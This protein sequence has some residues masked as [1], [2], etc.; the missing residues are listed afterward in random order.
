[1]STTTA[2][3]IRAAIYCRISHDKR[4]DEAG[5]DRQ[6]SASIA[7]A[8][9]SGWEIPGEPYVDNDR[10]AFRVETVDR[11][12]Y[13]AL[14]QAVQAGE[15]DVIVVWQTSRLWRDRVERAQ[16]MRVLARAGVSVVA[17]KG[18]SLDMTNA[19]GQFMGD[20]VGAFDTMESAVKSERVVAAMEQ[21]AAAGRPHGRRAYGWDR[22][23]DPGTGRAAD[24]INPKESAIVREIA[25]RII[26]GDSIHAITRDLNARDIPAPALAAWDAL[27]EDTRQRRIA[28]GRSRPSGVWGKQMVRAVVTRDRNAALRVHNGAVIGDAAWKPILDVAT[29]ERVKAILHDPA[30]RTSTGSAA[31]HLLSGIGMCG[32]CGAPVR[33]TMNRGVPSYKCSAASHVTRKRADVDEYVTGIVVGVLGRPDTLG[34]FAPRKAAHLD[35]ANEVRDLR[36]R[37]DDVA[38]AYADGKIGTGQLAR[39]TARIKPR[40]ED[41]ERRARQIVDGTPLLDGIT[42]LGVDVPAAW[43]A[44]PLSRKRAVVQL[45]MTVTID[46]AAQGART[47]DPATV[48][49]TPKRA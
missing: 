42:G 16:G 33:A 11:P 12:A 28:Q 40:L 35:A 48:R 38:D 20:M 9:S 41:A 43:Q 39:I 34:L 29:L 22:T 23:Y 24:V 47:F 8:K 3:T 27:D 10:S 1:M 6:R 44:L 26:H 13:R 37:L 45:L 31:K 32:V 18:P 2:D 36:Q 25:D 49:V 7:L 21:A 14:L 19:Y 4:G 30:R 5:V 46:R 15:V 17:V